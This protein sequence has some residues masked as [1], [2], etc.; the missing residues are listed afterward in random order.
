MAHAK[1]QEM[2]TFCS[3]LFHNIL[4]PLTVLSL[5]IDHQTRKAPTLQ[6]QVDTM[7]H[8]LTHLEYFVSL[9]C[10]QVRPS[11]FVKTF[12]VNEEIEMALEIVGYMAKRNN[13]QLLSLLLQEVSLTGNQL[14]F[15]QII[16]DVLGMFLK[17]ISKD[18]E[19]RTLEIT[20]EKRKKSWS[21][22]FL[23]TPG[24]IESEQV[25]KIEEII[26]KEFYGKTEIRESSNS[27]E[28]ILRFPLKI[29]ET[30]GEEE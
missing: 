18:T 7:I 27:A 4:N 2:E 10:G 11:S 1:T 22:S 5:E 14:Q 13:V 16:L 21:L 30:K 29:Q 23:T 28:L 9:L 25:K 15:H 3:T 26:Q 12:S 6:T 24:T 8:N 17:N 19:E 20:L